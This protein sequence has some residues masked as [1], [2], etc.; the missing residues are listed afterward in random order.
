MSDPAPRHPNSTWKRLAAL[1]AVLVVAAGML[2]GYGLWQE[3]DYDWESCQGPR[4]EGVTMLADVDI[5]Q[6]AEDSVAPLPVAELEFA[7]AL[8]DRPGDDSLYV[9]TLGGVVYEIPPGGEP[10]PVV[11]HT[12]EVLVGD[13]QGL[14]GIAFSPDGSFG[15]LT[16]IDQQGTLHLDEYSMPGF[17]DRRPV[18]SVP[19]PQKWHNGGNIHFGPDGF[20]YMGLGDGGGIADR[21][22]NGQD[23]DTVL[24]TII[25]IDPRPDGAAPYRIPADNPYVDGEAPE[26]FAYGLRNPWT[27]GFDHATGDLWIGDVGQNCVEEVD[28]VPVDSGGGQNFG[29]SALEGNMRVRG[30]LPDDHVLPVLAYDH[31]V[32]GC[33]ITVGDVYEGDA[34]PELRGK[35]LLGDYC[36]GRIMALSI[37]AD[38]VVELAEIGVAVPLL[39]GIGFDGEGEA[40]FLTRTEGVFKLVP[41]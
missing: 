4:V 40:Y 8:A 41:G 5:G 10:V 17:G 3:R 12:D 18:L 36:R 22:G 19:Q 6:W 11:D 33:S 30:T 31:P 25:R 32:G 29:W 14:L 1:S 35:L 2:A 20:L 24:G 23:L 34:I 9:T 37:A 27:F 21:Y 39:T 26:V 38:G 15:Y 28:L 7:V 16:F 13:E